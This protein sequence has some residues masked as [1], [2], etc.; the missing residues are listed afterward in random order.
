M[1]AIRCAR[2]EFLAMMGCVT[3]IL[4]AASPAGRA[5]ENECPRPAEYLAGGRPD[6]Y[7]AAA[8]QYLDRNPSA[9]AAA[10]VV[11]DVLVVASITKDA[12]LADEMKTRLLMDYSDS[13]YTRHVVSILG[14]YGTNKNNAGNHVS[15]FHRLLKK[16]VTDR[17][18][19]LSPAMA[20]RFCRAVRAGVDCLGSS[21]LGDDEFLLE[22]TV[23]AQAA[24]DY[25]LETDLADRLGQ[26]E[27]TAAKKIAAVAFSNRTA[28]EKVLGLHAIEGEPKARAIERL[29]HQRLAPQERKLPAVVKTVLENLVEEGKYRDAL[30]L[31]QELLAG[32]DDPQVR[33]LL[34]CC[35]AA[36]THLEAASATLA[37]LQ[38]RFPN[39]P[40][41]QA[42]KDLAILVKSLPANLDR[43]SRDMSAEIANL[44]RIG[45]DACE[46]KAT[47]YAPS[48]RVFHG[49]VAV[50]P[51]DGVVEADVSEDDGRILLAYRT[52][53]RNCSMY[54]GGEASIHEIDQNGCYPLLKTNLD[55]GADGEVQFSFN[56]NV[57][58]S[59]DALLASGQSLASSPL[60]ASPVAIRNLIEHYAKKGWL[61]APPENSSRGTIY[62][63]VRAEPRSPKMAVIEL[64]IT[65]SG[66]I[67]W[68]R[69]PTLNVESFRHGPSG[70]FRLSP[71][72]WPSLPVVRSDKV[73]PTVFFRIMSVAM[74][75]MDSTKKHDVAGVPP[76][77]K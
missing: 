18:D 73:D 25:R 77:Q 67:G 69:T 7:V 11:H 23:L 30:P 19:I 40:W 58:S 54:T 33:F 10:M 35:Q 61:P 20:E 74:S 17:K 27:D 41:S 4:L 64:L 34:A 70:S 55:Y 6:D 48:G 75:L 59:M 49:Y 68:L 2:R 46:C 12:A 60:L 36:E 76:Q 14:A 72:A 28:V 13:P 16:V 1:P 50:A 32:G 62:R 57:V 51:R 65:P 5:A 39:S 26:S 52:N 31:A 22:S 63:W 53:T 9:P 45:M 15:E 66:D 56:L 47:Y 8:R 24:G 42:G 21:A 43:Y 37:E 38:A 3:T 44:K 29:M 71:P